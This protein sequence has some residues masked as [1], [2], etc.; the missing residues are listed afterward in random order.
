MA[1]TATLSLDMSS[2]LQDQTQW[3]DVERGQLGSGGWA[4]SGFSLLLVFISPPD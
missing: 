4:L 3:E 1:V 2:Q